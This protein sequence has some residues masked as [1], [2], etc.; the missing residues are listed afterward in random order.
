MQNSGN[1]IMDIT[2]GF[3]IEDPN[4]FVPW[5][6]SQSQL[7][8]LLSEH[9][10][11]HITEGYFTITCKSMGGMEHELGFHFEP[12]S[13]D[14]LYELEFFRRSYSD[15]KKSYQEFQVHFEA[16]FG[17]PNFIKPGYVGFDSCTWNFQDVEILHYVFDRFGPEEHMRIRKRK[18]LWGC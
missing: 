13:G 6:V 5:L 14:F 4:V 17:K 18:C 1:K 16:V 8:E 7:R 3:Q 12:R 15:Q 11:T 9:G 2:K 10:L